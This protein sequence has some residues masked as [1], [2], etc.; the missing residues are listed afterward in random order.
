LAPSVPDRWF[1]G[2][3]GQAIVDPVGDE[4][5]VRIGDARAAPWQ[6]RKAP[7][8]GATPRRP[9]SARARATFRLAARALALGAIIAMP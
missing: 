8:D 7:V 6:R 9:R 2:V 4:G 5:D 3:F 1:A